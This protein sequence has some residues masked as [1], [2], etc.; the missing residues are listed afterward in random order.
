[1]LLKS[2]VW[3][4]GEF[5]DVFNKSVFRKHYNN[6][7]RDHI[8]LEQSS[9]ESWLVQY[10]EAVPNRKISFYT[11]GALAA[12]LLDV[13]IRQGSNNSRSLDTVMREMYDRFGKTGKGYTRED[14]KAIAEAQGGINL[15]SYFADYISGTTPMEPALAAA[16][17]YLGL[18]LVRRAAGSRAERE[19]GFLME[20]DNGT[21]KVKQVHEGSPAEEAGLQP[22]DQIIAIQGH[23]APIGEIESLLAFL[24]DDEDMQLH[25]FRNDV[26]EHLVLESRADYEYAWYMLLP[27]ADASSQ[28]LANR[29][30]WTRL[31]IS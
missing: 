24:E 1:M 4:L 7:G 8:S 22:G 26:L 20:N 11:K 15:D 31:T 14:Y 28:Q 6:Q 30:A 10:K 29:D 5:L 21:A 25:I 3:G 19:Y 17:D 23:R 9:F 12:F 2:G 13:L 27:N 16:A 18:S